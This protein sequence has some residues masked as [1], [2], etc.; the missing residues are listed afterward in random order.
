MN[1]L[2]T[3]S[4]GFVGRNICNEIVK[5][6]S[7]IG[8]YN[9]NNKNKSYSNIKLDLCENLEPSEIRAIFK[10]EK[11]H[12]VIHLAGLLADKKNFRNFN[13]FEKNIKITRNLI[14]ICKV[15]KPKSFINF[16]T[17]SVYPDI[18]GAYDEK[19][20]FRINNNVDFLYG[21]S[22][23][24]SEILFENYFK[25][26]HKINFCNLRVS[27]IY[28]EGM[29]QTRIIPIMKKELRDKNSIT[30]FGNGLRMSNFIHID[31][32]SKYIVFILS[33][34][35]KGTYNIGDENI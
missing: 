11:I 16:S 33:K 17:M 21:F 25:N 2:V 20:V 7:I 22:K 6:N 34:K 19:T 5:K 1:I 23:Y 30:V 3:G 31:K 29:N 28:G 12:S 24:C 9:K 14:D 35:L 8:I 26:L 15:I 18:S 27:Q 13:L 10:G 32:L 4:S